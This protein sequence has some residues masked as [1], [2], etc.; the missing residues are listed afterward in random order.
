[1][2]KSIDYAVIILIVLLF[3]SCNKASYSNPEDIVVN[4][5]N[6]LLRYSYYQED[7]PENKFQYQTPAELYYHIPDTLKGGRYTFFVEGFELPDYLGKF[8]VSDKS[9]YFGLIVDSYNDTLYCAQVLSGSSAEKAGLQNGDLIVAVDSFPLYGNKRVFDAVTNL[10]DT[11]YNFTIIRSGMLDTLVVGKKDLGGP[12]SYSAKFDGNV[13]YIYLSTF[14]AN[15]ETV[16]G[17]SAQQFKR[18]LDE[19]S[20]CLV[21][22][23]DLRG[24]GGGYVSQA[25]EIVSNFIDNGDTVVIT[26]TPGDEYT[27][28]EYPLVTSKEPTIGSRKF[29]LLANSGSASASEMMISALRYN[30]GVPLVGDTTYGK[31]IGQGTVFFFEE[32]S[33]GRDTTAAAHITMAKYVYP[34][35]SA[36]ERIG[37]VPDYVKGSTSEGYSDAQLTEAVRVAKEMLGIRAVTKP[38]GSAFLEFNRGLAKPVSV[39]EYE[40]V[41]ELL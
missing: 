24:N 7:I 41:E 4:A 15:E 25:V 38:L 10:G 35:G 5:Y 33:K 12:V 29:V 18:S 14:L 8:D 34:D 23:I 6:A 2:R 9:Y 22:V 30:L 27:F 32:T 36:Y 39:V 40:G 11:T 13:G 16:G 26:Q 3:V 37:F 21:T 19:T 1:M 17:S 28:K 31:A 20:E